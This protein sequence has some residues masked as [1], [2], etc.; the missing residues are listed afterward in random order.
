M[1]NGPRPGKPK[2]DEEDHD[3]DC[4]KFLMIFLILYCLTEEG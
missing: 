1:N 3:G 2:E 4:V